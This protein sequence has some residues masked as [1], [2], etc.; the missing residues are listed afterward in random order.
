MP[1]SAH[2]PSPLVGEAGGGRP[3]SAGQENLL[4]AEQSAKADRSA[5]PPNPSHEGE[6]LK[7]LALAPDAV[8]R[9]RQLRRASTDA[10]RV[11]WRAL[12]E[13]FPD[14]HWRKQVPLGAYF[15]DFTSHAAKLI[16]EVDGG[17]H[18]TAVHDAERTR[19]I[20]AQGYRVLRFWNYDVLSNPNG[21]LE[22]IAEELST[23]PSHC[24]ATGPSLSQGR[25]TSEACP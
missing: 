22:R 13:V 25:G 9:A 18:A 7:R 2:D 5:P 20:E 12:R 19:F 6:G 23:S 10:E 14:W 8:Q 11:L 3:A 21:V 24:F 1:M 17:Q 15:A 4:S 16:I